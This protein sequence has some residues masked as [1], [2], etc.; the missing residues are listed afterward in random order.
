[1]SNL[2]LP[3]RRVALLCLALREQ[4]TCRREGEPTWSAG[5]RDLRRT[6]RY[7]NPPAR[8]GTRVLARLSVAADGGFAETINGYRREVYTHLAVAAEAAAG[9]ADAG[10]AIYAAAKALGLDFVPL[11]MERYELA[12]TEEVYRTPVLQGAGAGRNPSGS[13]RNPFGSP[14]RVRH[15]AQRRGAGSNP[16]VMD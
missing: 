3:D 4:G 12:V 8:L 7:V 10:M 11:T 16:G 2:L 5:N 6:L 13:C 14:R 1:M 15:G 9:G